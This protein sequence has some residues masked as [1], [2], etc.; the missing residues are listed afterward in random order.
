MKRWA[1]RWV[2][3]GCQHNVVSFPQCFDSAAK[4]ML[5]FVTPDAKAVGTKAN[6]YPT[7]TPQL[8]E[9]GGENTDTVLCTTVQCFNPPPTQDTRWLMVEID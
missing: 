4:E 1:S 3:I 9:Y 5:P 8:Y 7:T 6:H 2:L